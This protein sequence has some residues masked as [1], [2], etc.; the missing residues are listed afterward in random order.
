[1]HCL[2]EQP[3]G[4]LILLVYVQPKASRNRIVGLHGDAVKISI[5]APP[6]DGKANAGVIK[7][8]A[9]FFHLPKSAITIISGESSRSKRLR[10]EGIE[11]DKAHALLSPCL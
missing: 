11:P 4:S 1:M 3:D 5:T 6:V 9:K 8:L 10:L 7:L 2:T